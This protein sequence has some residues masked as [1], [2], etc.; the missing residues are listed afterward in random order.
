MEACEVV[1]VPNLNRKRCEGVVD[2]VQFG[3]LREGA[4]LG[5]QVVYTLVSQV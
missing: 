4:D 1:Q 3:D 2:E 5:R